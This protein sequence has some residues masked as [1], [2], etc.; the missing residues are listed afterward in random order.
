MLSYNFKQSVLSPIDLVDFGSRLSHIAGPRISQ[1]PDGETV[2]NAVSAA[3]RTLS[4]ATDRE[5]SN[6]VTAQIHAMDAIRDNDL[7]M[8]R[9]TIK[10]N[11]HNVKNPEAQEAATALLEVY[12]QHVP[13]LSDM[14][15]AAES[16]AVNNLIDSLTGNGNR[17]KCE[18]IG[19]VPL[20]EG[21]AQTQEKLEA[22]YVER[23]RLEPELEKLTITNA[24]QAAADAIR[25]FLGF[26]DVMVAAGKDG[27]AELGDEIS[28]ILTDVEA[29]ARARRTKL[30]NGD[31]E[32]ADQTTTQAA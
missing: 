18:L 11:T 21:L 31:N 22:L 1:E 27:A 9:D 15:L 5:K 26:V 13:N 3:T 28:R 25:A 17:E 8:I 12:L 2:T 7:L 23:T 24:S 29:I 6:P 30:H 10:T 4:I 14:G 20:V 16:K 32:G 19:L